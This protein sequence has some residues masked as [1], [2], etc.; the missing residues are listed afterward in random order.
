LSR[1]STTTNVFSS[2]LFFFEYVNIFFAAVDQN[3]D[4]IS[5]V[6]QVISLLRIHKERRNFVNIAEFFFRLSRNARSILI[7]PVRLVASIPEAEWLVS[8]FCFKILLDYP[9][10][11]RPEIAVV[12]AVSF[13][14]ERRPVSC[15]HFHLFR[16]DFTGCPPF[17]VKPVS[18]HYL[19]LPQMFEFGG[20]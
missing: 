14:I 20:K 3:I 9:H 16:L 6:Q 11:Q 15:T 8:R 2:S 18:C 12:G 4:F 10:S 19:T 7:S 13:I 5:I 17:P 1:K